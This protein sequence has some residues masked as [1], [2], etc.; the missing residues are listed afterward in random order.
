MSQDSGFLKRWSARKTQ[1]VQPEPE[2]AAPLPPAVAAAATVP[3][4]APA[5]TL[6]EPVAEPALPTMEDVKLLTADSD[7]TGFMRNGVTPET[8][9]AALKKLFEDPHYNIMDMMDVYVDDYSKPDPIP[10]EM[11]RTLNQSFDLGLFER[12]KPEPEVA[13]VQPIEPSEQVLSEPV[14]T[15]HP[16]ALQDAAESA[17]D[18]ATDSPDEGGDSGGGDAP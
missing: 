2:A 14:A 11:L 9:N 10:P 3:T 1:A 12:P 5:Q 4:V 8:R 7:F 17:V 15:N 16:S 6:V 18:P 13:Q